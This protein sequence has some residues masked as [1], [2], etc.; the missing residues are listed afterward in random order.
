MTDQQKRTR[1]R[2]ILADPGGAIAPGATDALFARL[3]QSIIPVPLG[4]DAI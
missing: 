1:L 2:E 4:T 3:A